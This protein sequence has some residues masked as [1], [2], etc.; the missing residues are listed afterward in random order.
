MLATDPLSLMFIGCF[1][2]GLVYFIVTALLGNLA[3]GSADGSHAAG[4]HIDAHI[5]EH[6]GVHTGVHA[7]TVSHTHTNGH[8]AAQDHAADKTHSNGHHQSWASFLNPTSVMF[9]LLGFGFFGYVFHNLVGLTAPLLVLFFAGLSGV[10]IALLLL[11]MI[12]RLF[13]N[14]ES[15]TEQDVSDRTGL[16][17]K[18]SMTIQ[19]GGLGE[20]LY[21]SPGGMRKSIPARSLDGQRLERDQEVV[22]VSYQNGIAEVDTWEHFINEEGTYAGTSG[23][24]TMTSDGLETLRTLLDESGKTDSQALVMRKDSQKE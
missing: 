19:E 23:S 10:V 9:F 24:S 13:G 22:V 16:L 3:H 7:H 21:V 14:S 8:V 5:G 11:Y 20:V 2:V 4:H 15:A 17:G 1:L 12:T 6:H 18:V